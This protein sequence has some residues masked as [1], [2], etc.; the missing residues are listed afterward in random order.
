MPSLPRCN[1]QKSPT[2]FFVLNAGLSPFRRAEKVDGRVEPGHD[3]FKSVSA[4]LRCSELTATNS[5]RYLRLT[6]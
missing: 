6:R 1:A 4:L 3:A 5:Q 2:G